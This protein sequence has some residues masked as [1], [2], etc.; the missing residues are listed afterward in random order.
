MNRP[1]RV[2]GETYMQI[3]FATIAL[4]LAVAAVWIGL[5]LI[6]LLMG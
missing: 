6:A 4:T 2:S 3:E 5:I 1:Y